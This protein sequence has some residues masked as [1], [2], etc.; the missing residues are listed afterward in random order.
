MGDRANQ[1]ALRIA[2]ARAA[3]ERDDLA[4]ALQILDRMRARSPRL[5]TA[6][7]RL[8]KL[9]ANEPYDVELAA[10]PTDNAAMA[11]ALRG[12]EAALARYANRAANAR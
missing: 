2:A 12:L 7:A 4:G 6:I 8:R 5:D 3:I 1:P 9:L 10:M 11:N